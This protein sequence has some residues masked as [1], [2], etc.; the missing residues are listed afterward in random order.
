[1]FCNDKCIVMESKNYVSFSLSQDL[2]IGD[3]GG[4]WRDKQQQGR[5]RARIKDSPT[6]VLF[7]QNCNTNVW[8]GRQTLIVF[9]FCC[10][11]EMCVPGSIC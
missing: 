10:C 2:M 9:F 3:Y 7:S 4:N 6:Q 11:V 5:R 8:T 1:M